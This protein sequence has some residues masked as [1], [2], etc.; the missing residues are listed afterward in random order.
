[1][2]AWTVYWVLQLDGIRSLLYTLA[3]LAVVCAGISTFVGGLMA[4][5]YNDEET[6]KGKYILGLARKF[7]VAFVVLFSIGI[8]IPSS[9]TAA[10]MIVLPALTSEEVVGTVKSEA[11]ELYEMAKEALKEKITTEEKKVEGND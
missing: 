8:L 6:I 7:V 2:S 11:K 1:M 10:A 3:V 9:K 5:G 4:T